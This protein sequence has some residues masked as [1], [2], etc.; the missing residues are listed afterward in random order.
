MNSEYHQQQ[1]SQHCRVCAHA[2][3]AKAYKYP[4][5][6]YSKELG[7]AFGVKVGGDC[8]EV[9]PTCFCN[10]CYVKMRQ[11]NS[12]SGGCINSALVP[13]NWQEH[14]ATD[15]LTC[16]MFNWHTKAGRPRKTRKNRGRPGK[17]SNKGVIESLHQSA[18][19]TWKVSEP[20]SLSRFLPPAANVSLTDLQCA[21]CM[22][23]VDRPVEM[24]CGKLVC[25]ECIVRHLQ[26]N[27]SQ[28]ISCQCCGSSHDV[29]PR[30]AAEVIVKVVGSLLV[31]CEH[32]GCGDVVQ[33]QKLRGHMESGCRMS[34]APSPSKTTVS[35]ILARP[36]SAPPTNA[37]R[38]VA[39]SIVK[40][41]INTG[42]SPDVV[43]LPTAGQVSSN[44]TPHLHTSTSMPT[45]PFF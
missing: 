36:L 28:P 16:D 24:S 31:H 37:E 23:I 2:I 8:P 33:L 39:T 13:Y 26:D 19:P 15:C 6:K 45:L 41:L 5:N 17:N 14:S 29:S 20:L 35:Q 34:G 43:S 42:S 44:P 32:S 1:L 21:L 18:P 12:A 22:C 4:C 7:T 27:E 9:H 10:T 25:C 11:Y 38:K 3:K 40:R 30:P